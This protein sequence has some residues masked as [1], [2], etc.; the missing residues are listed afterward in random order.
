MNITIA[1]GHPATVTLSS[2]APLSQGPNWNLLSGQT[3]A[4]V[5]P[6]GMSAQFIA[7][8]PNAA[9]TTYAVSATDENNMVTGFILAVDVVDIPPQPTPAVLNASVS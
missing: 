9:R 4:N 8:D 1:P 6:D 5:A 2:S 7:T 3:I